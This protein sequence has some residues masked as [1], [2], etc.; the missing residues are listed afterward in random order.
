MKIEDYKK[1][2]EIKHEGGWLDDNVLF[3]TCKICRKLIF[4]KYLINNWY[5]LDNDQRKKKFYTIIRHHISTYH[6]ELIPLKK[7]IKL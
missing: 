2:F 3:A 6:H 5:T 7:M 1:L 4:D